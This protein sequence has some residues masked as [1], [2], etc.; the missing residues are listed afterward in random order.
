[1]PPA[2]PP[3]L[4]PLFCGVL[5]PLQQPMVLQLRAQL[6][7][8]ELHAAPCVSTSTRISCLM[9]QT[10]EN[11]AVGEQ[12]TSAPTAAPRRSRRAGRRKAPGSYRRLANPALQ[13]EDEEEDEEGAQEQT[14]V[15]KNVTGGRHWIV[16]SEPERTRLQQLVAEQQLLHSTTFGMRPLSLNAQCVL[17]P[18][19]TFHKSA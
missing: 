8:T 12:H 18:I 6:Q 1:M 3:F 4:V 2:R 19:P 14:R 15:K 16:W 5:V 11:G 9:L 7:S 10:R 13:H 17:S